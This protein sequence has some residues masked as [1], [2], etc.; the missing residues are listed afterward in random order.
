MSMIN[1]EI[2]ASIKE[3]SHTE[4]IPYKL[5]LYTVSRHALICNKIIIH[6]HQTHKLNPWK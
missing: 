3:K 6:F 5:T 1:E 4:N 2:I